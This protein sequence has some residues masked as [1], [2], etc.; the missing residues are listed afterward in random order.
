[1]TGEVTRRLAHNL[2]TDIVPWH[3]WDLA[4]I[5]HFLVGLV[6]VEEVLNTRVGV[7]L[8]GPELAVV[9]VLGS[10]AV[11]LK[12]CQLVVY[13]RVLGCIPAPKAQ[14][15]TT[16]EGNGMIDDANL[17][18]VGPE[19]GVLADLVWRAL[20]EDVWMEVE[21]GELGV[22][23]I[24]GDSGTDVAVHDDKDLDALLGLALQQPVE[25]PLLTNGSWTT[26]RKSV[27]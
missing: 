10:I 24:D 25:P 22:L 18:V 26:D 13:D 4:A 12:P 5:V 3:A 14:I 9:G 23:R 16:H 8:A 27:E 21:Q 11:Q 19:E 15:D 7:V 20:N 1:M 6:E 17:L 2:H